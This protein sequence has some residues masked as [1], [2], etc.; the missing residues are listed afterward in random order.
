MQAKMIE[1]Y[2]KHGIGIEQL[3]RENREHEKNKEV[4]KLKEK[5]ISLKRGE[6]IIND[7]I[8]AGVVM[9]LVGGVTDLIA[10]YMFTAVLGSLGIAVTSAIAYKFI[11]LEEKNVKRDISKKSSAGSNK[12]ATHIDIEV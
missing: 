1:E 2:T 7:A 10:P 8:S 12:P 6:E 5:L 3:L 4:E 11:K 9:G